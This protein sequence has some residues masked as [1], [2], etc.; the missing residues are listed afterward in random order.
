MQF[1]RAIFFVTLMYMSLLLFINNSQSFLCYFFPLDETY[2]SSIFPFPLPF[3]PNFIF[4]SRKPLARK[5]LLMAAGLQ[6]GVKGITANYKQLY[7]INSP[8]HFKK[9]KS[10]P[11]ARDAVLVASFCVSRLQG[12]G[13]CLSHQR[14]KCHIKHLVRFLFTHHKLDY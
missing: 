2:I 4:S 1:L 3:L 10:S 6:L 13:R 11:S 5:D 7:G 12:S 9:L 8:S 14:V